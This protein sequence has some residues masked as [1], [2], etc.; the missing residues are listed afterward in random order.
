MT[1]PNLRRR[2]WQGLSLVVT[3]VTG[4]YVLSSIQWN[5]HLVGDPIRVG[6]VQTDADG[7]RRFSA[8]DGERISL[9]GRTVAPG[10]VTLLRESRPMLLLAGSVVGAV[11]LW[12]MAVRWRWLLRSEGLDPGLWETTRMTWLGAFAGNFFPGSTGVDVAKIVCICR[13]A[14]QRKIAAVMTVLFSRLIGMSSLLLI[15]FVGLM[16]LP[17]ESQFASARTSVC[18]LAASFLL[19]SVVLMNRRLHAKFRVAER[20]AAL[21]QGSRLV[22]VL[23]CLQ[24][25]GRRPGLVLGSLVLSVAMQV[26]TIFGI[27]MFG[28]A[29]GMNVGLTHYFAFVPVIFTAASAMPAINGLGVR[30]GAFQVLFATAGATAS[31]ALALSVLHRALGLLICLPGAIVFHHE[32]RSRRPEPAEVP[33]RPQ[34]RAA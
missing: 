23:E 2:F 26:L 32:V 16:L 33:A 11:S 28:E 25:Y 14:P 34:A 22:V 10:I 7:I 13:R 4:G 12:L 20:L 24:H 17:S 21:P 18:C 30:E 3:L 27:A 29:I 31:Q 6:R 19:G 9:E 5:D 1:S 8:F 15:G